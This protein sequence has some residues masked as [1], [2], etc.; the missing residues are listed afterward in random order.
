MNVVMMWVDRA[1][2]SAREGKLTIFWRGGEVR[3]EASELV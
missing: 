1:M 3:E 2:I